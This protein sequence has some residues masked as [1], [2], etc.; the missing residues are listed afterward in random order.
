VNVIRAWKD[1]EYRNSLSEAE[2][3]AL[4]DNPAGLAELAETDLDKD[5]G[6]AFIWPTWGG[7]SLCFPCIYHLK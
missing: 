3:A 2:R 5:V 7:G 1:E 4:P 6:G